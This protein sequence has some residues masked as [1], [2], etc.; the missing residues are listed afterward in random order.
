MSNLL[1]FFGLVYISAVHIHF[2]KNCN[3]IVSAQRSVCPC[4][5][6]RIVVCYQ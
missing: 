2:L 1:R 4:L 6:G 3:I 5:D